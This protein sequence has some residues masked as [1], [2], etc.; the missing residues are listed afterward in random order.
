[1]YT[2]F[3]GVLSIEFGLLIGEEVGGSYVDDIGMKSLL[4]EPVAVLDTEEKKVVFGAVSVD[5][6]VSLN[7]L[8]CKKFSLLTPEYIE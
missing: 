4:V 6:V 8:F 2:I 1:M 5:V 3:P 7:C